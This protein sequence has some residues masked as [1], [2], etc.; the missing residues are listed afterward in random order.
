[1][2]DGLYSPDGG[3]LLRRPHQRSA[4][5]RRLLQRLPGWPELPEQRVHLSHADPGRLRNW[6][7]RVLH[8]LRDR[9]D[10]LRRLRQC[11]HSR[12]DVRGG[13]VRRELLDRVHGLPAGQ[14]R[15]L[16][17]RRHARCQQLWS[18]RDRLPD[19]RVLR[20]RHLQVRDRRE[21]LLHDWWDRMFQ[22][23]ERQPELR[24]LW[25]RLR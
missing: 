9:S 6:F 25:Q 12:P 13:Q 16:L 21:L 24:R 20:R 8:E 22:P 19:G 7:E 10:Q 4:E 18:L 3:S 17:R 5:L 2:P 23:A 1:M 11:L 14:H 15:H